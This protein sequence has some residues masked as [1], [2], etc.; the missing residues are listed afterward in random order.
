[1]KPITNTMMGAVVGKYD[2]ELT[3]Q[4]VSPLS[5]A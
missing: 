4:D 3:T 5:I 1:M 2:D